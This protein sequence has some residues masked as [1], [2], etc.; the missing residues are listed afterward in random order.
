[1]PS[2]ILIRLSVWPQY[3]NVTDRQDRQTNRQD[4]IDRQRTDSIGRTVLQTVAQKPLAKVMGMA[5]L[6]SPRASKTP[7]RISVNLGIYNYVAGMTTHANLCGAAAIGGLGEHVT[8][9]MLSLFSL[10]FFFYLIHGLAP[11]RHQSIRSIRHVRCFCA[12]RCL[13]WVAMRLLPFRG[14]MPQKLHF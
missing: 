1:M 7:Q 9:H 6:R 11:S 12:R 13:L 2:F 5:K 10:F 8:C 3:T 4:R 14:Q